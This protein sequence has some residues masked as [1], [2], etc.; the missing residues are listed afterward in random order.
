ML[1]NEVSPCPTSINSLNINFLVIFFD[2]FF[3]LEKLKTSFFN[4][5]YFAKLGLRILSDAQIGIICLSYIN[6]K[7]SFKSFTSVGYRIYDS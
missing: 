2:F 4:A 6:S 7:L 1:F 3:L 5:S